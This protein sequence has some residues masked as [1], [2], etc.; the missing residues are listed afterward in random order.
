M[1]EGVQHYLVDGG[2]EGGRERGRRKSFLTKRE[3]L[4]SVFFGE[5]YHLQHLMCLCHQLQ[6]IE[7][8]LVV[9]ALDKAMTE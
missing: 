8:T 4:K 6:L 3:L 2:R 1:A 9:L 5:N 7:R